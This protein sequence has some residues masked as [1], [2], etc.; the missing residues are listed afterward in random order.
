[1]RV[2]ELPENEGVITLVEP[3]TRSL[4][5]TARHTR[6]TEQVILAN[7]DQVLFVFAA[8]EPVPHVRMLDRF[9]ILAELQ[10]I[11]IRIAVTKMDLVASGCE[12]ANHPSR[13]FAEYVPLFPVHFL[14]VRSGEGMDD[15]MAGLSGLVTAVAGPSGVGKSSL[16]N[17]LDPVN[18][19]DIGLVSSATGKGKHTTVGTRIHRLGGGTFVADTP[20]MRSIAM[21]ATPPGDLDWCYREFR[22]YLGSCFYPDCTHIHEPDCDVRE[23]VEHGA[24][25]RGRYESY[26]LLRTGEEMA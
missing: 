1:M 14:C 4:V 3:R 18:E 21:H 5:R 8:R 13:V 2:L 17:V 16:L 10:E 19:R 25:G 20:G 6:D 15:L 9:I 12:D 7:P 24:I 23:A 26:V 22:P 11:P